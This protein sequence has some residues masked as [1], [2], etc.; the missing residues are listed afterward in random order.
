MTWHSYGQ[1]QLKAKLQS[2]HQKIHR[3]QYR[4]K[5]SK[6]I[7]IEKEDGS[8]RPLGIA[9]LEDKI[10]QRGI[11]RVLEAIYEADFLDCS[12]AFRPGRS[13]HDALEAL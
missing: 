8:Q 1:T 10:V 2:L 5:P 9:S 13:A 3:E 12:Y 11:A 4:P 7:W 6:R